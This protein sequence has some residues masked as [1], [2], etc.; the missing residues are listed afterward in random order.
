MA[1]DSITLTSTTD[2]E[3]QVRG[4]LGIT[5]PVEPA[6]K[7]AA[8][9][10]AVEPAPEPAVEDG[11][12]PQEPLAQARR[13][14]GRLQSRIDE[15]TTE[16]N[17]VAAERAALQAEVEAYRARMRDMVQ[18]PAEKKEAA[19]A[20][21]VEVAP[22]PKVEDFAT[23]EEYTKAVAKWTLALDRAERQSE[24][25][26]AVETRL[27]ADRDRQK[28]NE[29]DLTRTQMQERYRE[30][31]AQAREKYEDFDDVINDPDLRASD[32]MLEQ[33]LGSEIG[34]EIAY[35]LGKNPETCKRLYSMGNTSLAL[36]EFGKVEAKVEAS[37][38]SAAA[39]TAARGNAADKAAPSVAPPAEVKPTAKVPVVTKAPDPITPVGTG[40]A[41]AV[42]DPSQMSYRD[43]RE[44]R[45]AQ[46]RKRAGLK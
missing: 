43:F 37:L 44:W 40:Q 6:A 34:P 24:I 29:M 45:N 38:S 17:R 4:A 10:P 19:A 20:P 11:D 27:K 26:K 42:V 2:T 22:E 13:R 1:T 25:D 15:L 14:K 46:E 28:R 31:E 3:S 39:P 36:K 35:Y 33:L 9:A 23:Y 8:N 16:R 30:N 32:T 12:E 7:V 5:D 18:S 41:T 21:V